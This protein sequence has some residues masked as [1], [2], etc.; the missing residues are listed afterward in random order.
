MKLSLIEEGMEVV[1]NNSISGLNEGTR[2]KVRLRADHYDSVES[3]KKGRIQ[4]G[5]IILSIEIEG[6]RY[7]QHPE[8]FVVYLKRVD[9]FYLQMEL[10]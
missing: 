8:N 1:I 6:R 7:T 4:E 5:D 3:F 9:P 10:F 2:G